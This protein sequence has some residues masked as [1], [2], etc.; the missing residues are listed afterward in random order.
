[1]IFFFTKG[2]KNFSPS[3]QTRYDNATTKFT[4]GLASDQAVTRDDNIYDRAA[5]VDTSTTPAG[6]DPN[7]VWT[8]S[9]TYLATGPYP[10]T[11]FYFEVKVNITETE[12]VGGTYHCVLAKTGSLV[13]DQTITLAAN[14]SHQFTFEYT[15]TQGAGT[16]TW[17][18]WV[19]KDVDTEG[20][21]RV[22]GGTNNTSFR[23][24][25]S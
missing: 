14:A 1:M 23:G 18:I 24:C 15:E 3:F 20:D 10:V 8:N 21:F 25:W 17:G 12:G 4:V 19:G 22:N 7:S 2:G 5:F 13:V 11:T 6:S 9:P 16:N